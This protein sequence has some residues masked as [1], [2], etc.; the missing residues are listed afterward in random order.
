M[1]FKN[2]IFFLF[3]HNIINYRVDQTA[4]IMNFV[5]LII[6]IPDYA[7]FKL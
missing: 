1:I 6:S 2:K 5:V 4:S 3:E 7:I